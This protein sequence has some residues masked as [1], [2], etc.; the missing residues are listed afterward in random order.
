MLMFENGMV[1]IRQVKDESPISLVPDEYD[2]AFDWMSHVAF[3]ESDPDDMDDYEEREKS[4]EAYF[5]QE[6][7][8]TI[9]Q[10]FSSCTEKKHIYMLQG[11]DAWVIA[12]VR[13]ED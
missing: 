3:L 13:Q 9:V 2:N 7:P 10:Y 12:R 11:Y 5:E 6:Y 4:W 8:R 1:T